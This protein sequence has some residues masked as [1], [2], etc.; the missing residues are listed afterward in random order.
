VALA[1]LI[2]VADTCYWLYQR[3]WRSDL[4]VTVIDV[5]H[6][7]ASLLELPGG[8]TMLIDGGGFS[9]NAAFDIGARVVAPILWRNKI[10]TV[11][12]LVL[13]HPNSDHLN[14]LIF[15]ADNFH[16]KR[17]WTNNETRPTLGYRQFMKVI[18]RNKIYNPVYADIARNHL[19]N[20]VKLDLLYPPH[21]FLMRKNKEKWR[22]SNNNSLVVK[23]S[24]GA[25]S[26]LFP[27]DIMKAG[28]K[29]IVDICDGKLSSTVLMAPH[30]GSRSS[31]SG[32]FLAQVK[33]EVVIISTGYQNRYQ[34]PDPAVLK[35]YQ[36][37]GCKIYRTDVNGAVRLTT[38]GNHLVIQSF[39]E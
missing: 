22:N 11:D 25:T 26:F 36:S 28:E 12:T 1:L 27:G 18:A 37:R 3:Y 34:F 39:H 20:G 16:V 33:P 32:L 7:S 23:V 17:I 10:R 4:R 30:H 31:S 13:S 5:G 14:G 19:V 24:L 38:D 15:I 8:Y 29:E 9:D 21:D 6:G 2:M 35:R